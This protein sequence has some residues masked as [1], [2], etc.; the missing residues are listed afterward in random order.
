[1][2][3]IV[4]PTRELSS[5][6]YH[7]AQPFFSTLP[8]VKTVLLVG[9]F[10]IKTDMRRIEEEGANILVGTPGK[11]HDVMERLDILDFRSFEIL[12]LDEADRLL[13]M[14][15]QKQITS[16]I[17]RLPKLRRTGLFS[18]TQ[19]EAVEELS[20]AGLRNPVR[21]EVRTEIKPVGNLAS[22]QELAASITP[23]G[24]HIEYL[25]CEA[26][27]KPSQLVDFLSQNTSKKIIM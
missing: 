16:I 23:L 12:I 9:G 25:E 3:M 17:S 11:L 20:R 2:G 7:V 5:Q 8:G 22:S 21:V 10:D 26:E 6:I 15:F 18:A 4:S 27:R 14:G 1:M 19:T 13:D 24:L